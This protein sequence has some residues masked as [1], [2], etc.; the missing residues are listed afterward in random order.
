MKKTTLIFLLISVLGCNNPKNKELFENSTDKLFLTKK[1]LDSALAVAEKK[2][3]NENFTYNKKAILNINS[4]DE[5]L[6]T[7]ANLNQL[8]ITLKKCLKNYN[9]NSNLVLDRVV[10]K[11]LNESNKSLKDNTYV[12]FEIKELLF[13][14]DLSSIKLSKALQEYQ[15]EYWISNILRN[16]RGFKVKKVKFLNAI[17]NWSFSTMQDKKYTFEREWSYGRNLDSTKLNVNEIYVRGKDTLISQMI[18]FN[19]GV[20]DST[21][22][23][24]YKTEINKINDTLF[25]GRITPYNSSIHSLGLPLD[26]RKITIMLYPK[27][28]IIQS[29]NQ[30][31]IDFTIT[32][33]T[34]SGFIQDVCFFESDSVNGQPMLRVITKERPID[35]KYR[36]NNEMIDA[37]EMFKNER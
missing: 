22:S 24:F 36:T 37:F 9:E 15:S 10:N 19:K 26:R 5:S 6:D 35:N 16:T 18:E 8:E 11:V 4:L 12:Y 14:H 23:D 31:F 2:L 33:D 25:K 27:Y 7:D 17:E 34:I 29:E 3:S 30:N 28:E 21:R 13:Q 20:L 32:N 1:V